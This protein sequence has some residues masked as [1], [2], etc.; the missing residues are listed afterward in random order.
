MRRQIIK[1][2]YHRWRRVV[3]TIR[4]IKFYMRQNRFG[5]GSYVASNVNLRKCHI[6]AYSIIGPNSILNRAIIGPYCSFAADTMVGGEEHAYWD[7]S[8]SDR[9]TDLG[10]CDNNTIFGYDVWVGAQCYIRQGVKIGNGAVIGSNSFVNKDIPDFAIV[11]GSPARIIKYRFDEEMIKKI[12]DSHY[13]EYPPKKQ[14][15]S[16]KVYTLKNKI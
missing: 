11:A 10:I 5:E 9:L 12:K 14:K 6:G 8:T 13:W 2:L 1:T 4:K 16:L 7:I 15:K 3:F